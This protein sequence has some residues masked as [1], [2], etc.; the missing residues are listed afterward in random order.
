M[1]EMDQEEEQ[2]IPATPNPRNAAIAE[3]AKNAHAIHSEELQDVDFAND[4]IL[5]KANKE[6]VSKAE[7]IEDP[8]AIITH[9]QEP[10]KRLVTIVVD[11]QRIEVDESKIIEAGKRTLQ[12]ESA[13]DR[14]L[15]EANEYLRRVKAQVSQ[16]PGQTQTIEEP[17]QGVPQSAQQSTVLDTTAIENMLENRLYLREASKAADQFKDEFQDIAS[18]P[19][20]MQLAA[21]L[22]D[23]RLAEA[24]ALGEPFGD[25]VKA[26]KAHGEKLREWAKS[27]GIVQAT[28]VTSEDK[29]ERKRQ[30]VAVPG[31]S[32]KQA[33]TKETKPLEGSALIDAMREARKAGRS[34]SRA[35]RLN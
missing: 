15:A 33:T 5:D 4:K 8:P 13:A 30:I 35:G 21:Q 1:N 20:L 29:I 7:V 23:Q 18:D 25:P 12:K 28:S 14:R 9:V 32:A 19:F 17:P 16:D 31:T 24:R 26:Y 10:E 22:E 11:G 6:P 34:V 27:K 2:L 3:V